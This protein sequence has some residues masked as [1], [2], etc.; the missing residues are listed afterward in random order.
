MQRLT[1]VL[2]AGLATAASVALAG[3]PPARPAPGTPAA[4]A[5][6]RINRTEFQNSLRDLLGITLD[7]EEALPADGS[8]H[9]FDNNADALPVSSFLLDAYLDAADRALGLAIAN[10]PQPRLVRHQFRPADERSVTST[11]ERVFRRR[12]DGSVVCFS[13]SQW[14][15][16][17]LYRFYPPDRGRY[18]FRITASAFQNGDR[19]VT[20]RVDAGPML[21]GRKNRLIGYFDAPPEARV[22]EFVEHLEARST[23]RILPHGI[24]TAH[25]LNAI[26]AENYTGPG[27]VLHSI[28][29]E[30]PLHDSWPPESHRRL[31]GDLPQAPVPGA[32]GRLEVVSADPEADAARLLR[33]FARRAY[34]RPPGEPEVQALLAL[35][36]REREAGATFE[37]SLR[38][39]LRAVLLSPGCMFLPTARA[40]GAPPGDEAALAARLAAFLWSSTPDDELLQLAAE[41]RLGR[42]EVLR[43][44]V[45]RLLRDPRAEALTAGFVDQWLGLRDLDF[46]EPDRLL[47]PDYDEM[48]R[49]AMGEEPRRFFQEVLTGDGSVLLFTDAPFALLN[50]RLAR[51]YGIAGVTGHAFRRVPLPPGSRRG[52]VLTMAGV[53]K[54]TANGTT[55]SPVV[56]GAWVLDRLLGAPPPPP[57]AGVPAVEPDIRGAVTIRDQLARHRADAACAA[58]HRTIDPPGFAL[59]N[60]DVIG[61]WREH[62][63]SLG[64]G[65]PV[66]VD[67]RRMPYAQGPPVDPADQLPDGSRFADVDEFKR[68]LLRD[69]DALARAFTRRL[70]TYAAGRGLT[71]EDEATVESLLRRLKAR[72]LGLRSLVHL[73][74]E[75]LR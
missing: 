50:E 48:L 49:A 28:E 68:L 73:I 44:Q 41:K 36:R 45:E 3:P 4:P 9:G 23:L 11:T 17:T 42:P 65:T 54:V 2:L 75:D 15:A 10:G 6:R 56:R 8:A 7:L 71:R 70:Y 66:V 63:R 19:P 24:A 39:G 14:N 57:P 32:Q 40:A 30:G 27:L 18:R 20:F 64:R 12:E 52:G 72:K 61:G 37:Q 26:G 33:A 21:M 43:A 38:V 59:E 47:Y 29:A 51:H 60:F 35:V 16:I 46:T 1:L 62:Y 69:P 22:F 55:T 53:L 58:C 25:T 74:A 5:L 34:R 13:S 31:L 67:G